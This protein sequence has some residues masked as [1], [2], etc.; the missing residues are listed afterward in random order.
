MVFVAE[1]V[2]LGRY[3]WRCKSKV[4][5]ER[6]YIDNVTPTM[7]NT[8]KETLPI[9]SYKAA[10]KCCCGKVCKGARGLEMH[11][12]SCRVIEDLQDELQQQMT[13]SLNQQEND[14]DTNLENLETST[15]DHK[16]NFLCLKKGIK[17]PKSTSQWSAANEFF[18]LTFSN[19]PITTQDLNNN[20]IEP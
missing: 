3:S 6:G 14:S 18:K 1:F 19:Q 11:Q 7:E 15:V 20:I 17:L 2:S 13:D 10:V 9:V 12:R 8:A 4:K 16:D 5:F